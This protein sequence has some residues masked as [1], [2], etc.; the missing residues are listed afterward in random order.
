M[1]NLSQSLLF[2]PNVYNI[3]AALG[4]EKLVYLQT[5]IDLRI[6]INKWQCLL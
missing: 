5:C 6:W 3:Y 2:I 1:S 4:L